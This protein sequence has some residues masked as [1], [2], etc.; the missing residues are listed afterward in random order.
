[1][2]ASLVLLSKFFAHLFICLGIHLFTFCYDFALMCVDVYLCLPAPRIFE[3]FCESCILA[4]ACVSVH[5]SI[6]V[7]RRVSESP[8]VPICLAARNMCLA[9]LQSS[10]VYGSAYAVSMCM[11]LVHVV[12]C[13]LCL[14][15][16]RQCICLCYKCVC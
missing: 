10:V 1:M 12:A 9:C 14:C 6:C 8:L 3:C 7:Y 13:L 5:E 16:C 2:T 11:L 4:R 15:T